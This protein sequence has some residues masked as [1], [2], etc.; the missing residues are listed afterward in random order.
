M[1]PT[2][3]P[4]ARRRVALPSLTPAEVDAR[5]ERVRKLGLELQ[6]KVGGSVAS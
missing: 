4:A 1:S 2:A 5:I 6:M 3:V